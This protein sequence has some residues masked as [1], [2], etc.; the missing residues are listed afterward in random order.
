[1]K[2]NIFCFVCICLSFLTFLTNVVYAV[3][4]FAKVVFVGM[5]GSGKTL[6]YQLTTGYKTD[7]FEELDKLIRGI[8]Q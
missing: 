1:M 5:Y 7:E 2:K 8:K 6:T 4:H 3:D